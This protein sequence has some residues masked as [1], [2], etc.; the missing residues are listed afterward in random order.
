MLP[1]PI[2]NTFTIERIYPTTAARVFQAFRDPAKK[3]RWFAEGVGFIIDSYESDFRVG[4][5][6]RTRFRFGAD[7][8]PMTNDCMY[9]EI[10]EN[11]RMIFAYSMTIGGEPLSTS[12]NTIE[13]LAASDGSGTLLRFTE[14]TIHLNGK[15]ASNGRREGSIGMLERLARELDAH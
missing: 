2:H 9:F 15:D 1:K 4:G 7:G 11:E 6:E 12:L 8:P 10:T 3:R 13:L 14:H 5:W